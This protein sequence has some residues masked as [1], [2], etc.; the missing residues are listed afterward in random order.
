MG[1]VIQKMLLN[2]IIGGLILSIAKLETWWRSISGGA[3]LTI[4]N[5]KARLLTSFF[6][7]V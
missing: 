1:I 6:V 2:S 7:F 5:W 4:H 3:R